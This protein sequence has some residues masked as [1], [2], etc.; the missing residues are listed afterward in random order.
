[1]D[2]FKLMSRPDLTIEEQ[3]SILEM[4]ITSAEKLVGD[5][6]KWLQDDRNK[7]KSTYGAIATDT[8]EISE[9]LDD[10]KAELED[11]KKKIA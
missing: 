1:M 9:K 8:R 7:R 3:V 6:N 2:Q 4:D 5:R 10:K 11:L